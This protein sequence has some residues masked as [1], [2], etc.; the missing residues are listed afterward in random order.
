[1]GC[2]CKHNRE[3]IE[4]G[5]ADFAKLR[6]YF[7]KRMTEDSETKDARRKEFNQAIFGVREDGS[8]Y[9][10]WNDTDMDMVLR[11]FDDAVRDWRNSWCDTPGC[12]A[13]R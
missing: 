7:I 10:V 6:I 3:Q 11:C 13:K 9:Q 5:Y 8:T 2:N 12:R 4:R 1:M